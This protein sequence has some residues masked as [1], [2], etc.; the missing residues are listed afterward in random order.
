MD[1][2]R[3]FSTPR[4]KESQADQF[5][6]VSYYRETFGEVQELFAHCMYRVSTTY[7]SD[8]ENL[9]MLPRETSLLMT[10]IFHS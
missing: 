1:L 8:D 6:N 3:I 7:A 10:V 5:A 4:R 2:R 9:I